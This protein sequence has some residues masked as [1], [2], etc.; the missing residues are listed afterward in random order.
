MINLLSKAKFRYIDSSR[1]DADWHSILHSHAFTELFYVVKGKGS[2]QFDEGKFIDVIQD[3][4]VIINPN[5]LHTEVSDSNDP[6]EYIVLGVDGIEFINEKENRGYSIHN[7]NDYKHE[8]LFSL[9]SLLS[10]FQQKEM[11]NQIMTDHLLNILIMNVIRRTVFDLRVHQGDREINKDCVF[12]ENY[13]NVHFK[14]HI[15][16]DK[17]ADMTYM[18]KYYLSHEFK[19]HTGHSPIEYLL[20]KRLKEA[21]KLLGTTDLSITQ[22]A[23]IVGFGS[24]SYFSQFFKK[25]K[26]MSPRE[27]RTQE[28][29]KR[30]RAS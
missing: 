5:V 9:K 27:Y 17:L 28:Q 15:T 26:N 10:E 8:I 21:E 4:L 20:N 24:S 25:N 18:N 13:I 30:N 6:L 7:Y 19:K 16:L 3:D 29:L 23:E 12:V 11:F 2:F 14:E 22:I 1:Y